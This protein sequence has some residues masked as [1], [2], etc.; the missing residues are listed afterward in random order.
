MV[1]D[2]QVGLEIERGVVGF[3]ALGSGA[4]NHCS[5][6]PFQAASIFGIFWNRHFEKESIHFEKQSLLMHCGDCFFRFQANSEDKNSIFSDKN[7][8]RTF[9]GQSSF[10]ELLKLGILH[11]LLRS[12]DGFCMVF[13]LQLRQLKDSDEETPIIW[14]QGYHGKSVVQPSFPGHNF[15]LQKGHEFHP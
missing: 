2:P 14:P 15:T 11:L 9:L 10:A 3:S 7:S 5:R 1:D 12:Q 6:G 13:C 8:A 4:P